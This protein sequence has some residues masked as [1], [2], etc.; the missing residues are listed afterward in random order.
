MDIESQLI[1][2]RALGVFEVPSMQGANMQTKITMNNNHWVDFVG[3]CMARSTP[4][5]VCAK[6]GLITPRR[7]LPQPVTI[8]TTPELLDA[9]ITYRP[10][11]LI[12]DSASR[13]AF[14]DVESYT[15]PYSAGATLEER[16][17]QSADNIRG[18]IRHGEA[19]TNPR[20]L[21][22]VPGEII[23]NAVDMVDTFYYVMTTAAL[24]K[25]SHGRYISKHRDV[26]TTVQ[27]SLSQ[28]T[29]IPAMA[30]YGER[31]FHMEM[32]FYRMMLAGFVAHDNAGGDDT[33]GWDIFSALIEEKCG[34]NCE[35]ILSAFDGQI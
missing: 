22:D 14:E 25:L 29:Y 31:L 12:S 21:F 30:L 5:S 35:D 15:S 13:H 16:L 26:L 32:L 20:F 3:E 9:G 11:R 6:N 2:H 23:T 18:A 1:V 33:T 7:F 8:I 27:E 4:L 34:K 10:Y 28:R 24:K 19:L 17:H